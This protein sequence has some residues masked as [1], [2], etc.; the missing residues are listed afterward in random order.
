MVRNKCVTAFAIYT[1]VGFATSFVFR[2]LISK[3]KVNREALS[4]S[5]SRAREDVARG[6]LLEL[7]RETSGTLV[8]NGIVVGKAR[9]TINVFVGIEDVPIAWVTKMLVP[10]EA[11]RSHVKFVQVEFLDG[12]QWS[13]FRS[14]TNRV[15]VCVGC[16]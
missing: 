14:C 7:R 9:D 1:F 15:K 12:Q 11:F 3:T 13:R 4:W 6:T 8:K 2:G 16:W 10:E 5:G